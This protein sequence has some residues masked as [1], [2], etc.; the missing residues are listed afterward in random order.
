M[1]SRFLHSLRFPVLRSRMGLLTGLLLVLVGSL[2]WLGGSALWVRWDR[3]EAEKALAEYDFA[4]ARRRLARCITIHPRDPEL[5]ML[6]AQT[7]R[8]DGDP[9]F[10]EQQLDVHRDLIGEL[11]PGEAL[12][13][14]LLMVQ[15]GNVRKVLDA[16]IEDLDLH[17]PE[18]E[19]ILEALVMGCVQ[20]YQG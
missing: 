9:D 6:A 2:G 7:A 14:A 4:E 20:D 12:E 3:G 11:S 18:S 15:R 10:A 13:R 1:A 16:L 19:H 8:R 5:R 17:H